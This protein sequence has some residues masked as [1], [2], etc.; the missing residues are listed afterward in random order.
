MENSATFKCQA[1]FRAQ[2]QR[3]SRL[4]AGKRPLLHPARGLSATADAPHDSFRTHR[5][6]DPGIHETAGEKKKT[7]EFLQRAGN[8]APEELLRENKNNFKVYIPEIQRFDDLKPRPG[9]R[10]TANRWG[11]GTSPC[12]TAKRCGS[13]SKTRRDESRPGRAPAVMNADPAVNVEWDETKNGLHKK[14][15]PY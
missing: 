12:G 6:S 14:K 8:Q 5:I 13:S 1:C 11:A 9:L 2:G 3:V 10:F 15:A 4:R 7:E